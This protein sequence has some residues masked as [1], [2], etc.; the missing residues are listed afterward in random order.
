MNMNNE[1]SQNQVEEVYWVVMEPVGP[2]VPAMNHV[3]VVATSMGQALAKAHESHGA[4]GWRCLFGGKL[5]EVID[6]INRNQNDSRICRGRNRDWFLIV[7][8]DC[9]TN[10]REGVVIAAKNPLQAR[11]A[12]W[13]DIR[14]KG[15]DKGPFVVMASIGSA[16]LVPPITGMLADLEKRANSR[17]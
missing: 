4:N 9:A 16:Q 13:R 12:A 1:S 5:K 2:G 7:I 6:L 10:T 15:A 11:K 8:E 14:S 17:N 3:L